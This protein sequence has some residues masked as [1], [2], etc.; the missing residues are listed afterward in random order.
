MSLEYQSTG[1]QK[2][3]STHIGKMIDTARNFS[4]TT[5][6]HG[7][8]YVGS[9]EHSKCGRLFWIAAVVLAI[10][11]TAFQ[12]FSILNQWNDQL[13]V[14]NLDTISLPVED[15]DFPSVTLCPQGATADVLD[16]VLYQQFQE[17]LFKKTDR[18]LQRKRRDKRQN[19]KYGCGCNV[20]KFDPMM[21]KT[22]KCCFKQFLDDLYPE[23]YPNIP[24]SIAAML[25]TNEPD[26]VLENEA[27]LLPK[28]ADSCKNEDEFEILDDMNQKLKRNCPT[29]FIKKLNDTTC[30]KKINKKMTY[31]KALTHC[32]EQMGA[33]LFAIDQVEDLITLDDLSS[34][35]ER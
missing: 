2:K 31:S 21:I 16:N 19:Q 17:W 7:I 30:L 9:H 1:H 33:T 14:T 28:K 34:K 10:A 22:L 20:P 11:G 27:I 18:N 3:W 24:T 13:V 8:V 5:S 29:S 35:S 32:K 4:S 23:V 6:I 15:V 26:Q 12:L 25:N